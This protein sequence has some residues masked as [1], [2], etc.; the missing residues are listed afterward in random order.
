MVMVNVYTSEEVQIHMHHRESPW[1][2]LLW[3]HAHQF[4]S[5]SLRREG[6]EAHILYCMMGATE[7]SE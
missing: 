3:L 4:P 2:V 5:L 1:E 7:K 6:G